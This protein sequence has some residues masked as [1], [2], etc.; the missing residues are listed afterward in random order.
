MRVREKVL[1]LTC[2]SVVLAACQPSL[3]DGTVCDGRI[4][5]ADGD[6]TLGR[7]LDEASNGD[8]VVLRAGSYTGDRSVPAG[9]VLAGEKDA[10]VILRGEQA[11]AALRLDHEGATLA[12][13]TLRSGTGLGLWITAPAVV[14]RGVTIE[15]FAQGA[16]GIRCQDAGCARGDG[17]ITIDDSVVTRSRYGIGLAAGALRLCSTSSTAHRSTGLSG[18]IGLF[19]TGESSLE[20]TGGEVKD[21]DL[22]MVLDGSGAAISLQ[23]VQVLGNLDRGLWAQGLRGSIDAPALLIRGAQTRISGNG[24]VGVGLHDSQDVRIEGGRIDGTV[25]KPVPVELGTVR[26][27]GDGLAV[28]GSSAR[29]HV[30]GA[31]LDN[32]GRSQALIDSGGEGIQLSAR[33]TVEAQQGQYLVVVQN[34][35]AS[36][37]VPA[38]LV[39][40]VSDLP[41]R[42]EPQVSVPELD[43]P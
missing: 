43:A 25:L 41:V 6:E 32:N 16:V 21:S 34:T 28:L 1:L 40:P 36:V 14:V 12:N 3:P 22:G 18:G 33:T 42:G 24:Y 10:E 35:Q 37:D 11:P 5:V 2:A 17:T 9:V 8:C 23:D 4:L 20:M 7:A 27:I 31:A 19:V 29:I 13:L 26:D 38:N 39:S 15:D 30:D